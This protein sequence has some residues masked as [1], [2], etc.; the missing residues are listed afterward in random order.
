M[1]LLESGEHCYTKAISN[2][3]SGFVCVCVQDSPGMKLLEEE[4]GKDADCYYL[5]E[6]AH[7]EVCDIKTSAGS[8]LSIGSI[9]LIV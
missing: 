3:Y 2:D 4:N 9:I 6:L 1:S 7:P 5:F 8:S